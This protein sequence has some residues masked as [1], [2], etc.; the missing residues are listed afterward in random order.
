LAS[1]AFI[2]GAVEAMRLWP[3]YELAQIDAHKVPLLTPF[4]LRKHSSRRG[5]R[6]LA[7]SLARNPFTCD[8]SEP[9]WRVRDGRVL[10]LRA[11]AAET[12]APF[13]KQ[14]RRL[15]DDETLE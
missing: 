3:S 10:S 11:V 15:S 4:Q 14:I 5:W 9:L 6:V 12:L 8:V 2:T 13:R 1:C 7:S